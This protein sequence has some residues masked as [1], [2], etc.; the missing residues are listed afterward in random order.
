MFIRGVSLVEGSVKSYAGLGVVEL[1]RL[2]RVGV[3]RRV[4]GG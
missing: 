1:Y 3:G 4:F 2:V